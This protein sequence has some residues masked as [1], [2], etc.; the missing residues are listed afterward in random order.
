[1]PW[2]CPQT[3]MLPLGLCCCAGFLLPHV[4]FPLGGLIQKAKARID[5]DLFS[6]SL[7]GI[8]SEVG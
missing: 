2:G 1:M 4:A 8:K 3:S 7:C 6:P 5:K